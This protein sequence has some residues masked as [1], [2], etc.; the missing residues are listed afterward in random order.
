MKE[1]T[2]EDWVK[3]PTP[4]MMWVWDDDEQDKNKEMVVYIKNN[5]QVSYPVVTA[6]DDS[7]YTGAYAHC[8]EITEEEGT[9]LNDYELGQLFRCMGVEWKQM[10]SA[11]IN[12][13]WSYVEGKEEELPISDSVKIRYKQGAWEEPTRETVLKWES[14]N[15]DIARFVSFMGWR[16]AVAE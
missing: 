6:C 8:A 15:S 3:N 7:C 13:M 10:G 9:P 4:R 11:F 1:I 14:W 2:S 5:D 16:E 12:E